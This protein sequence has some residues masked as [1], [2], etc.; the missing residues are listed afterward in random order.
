MPW[1][2][3][4]AKRHDKKVSSPKQE[5]QWSDVANSVLKETGDEGR[6]VRE[7]N[8]VAMKQGI[9]KFKGKA[10]EASHSRPKRRVINR[11]V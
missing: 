3:E 10:S 1:K 7:A 6:A 4:D 2:P 8:G 9:A 11:Y 5:R